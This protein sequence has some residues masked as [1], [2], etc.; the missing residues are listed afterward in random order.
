M[1]KSQT[2]YEYDRSER[3]YQAAVKR[4]NEIAR[5]TGTELDFSMLQLTDLPPQIGQLD[6]LK[7]LDLSNNQLA[8]LPADIGRLTNLED[9]DLK[10]N[11]L[12]SLPDEL[13][14]LDKLRYLDLSENP[15]PIPPEILADPHNPQAILTFYF[16]TRAAEAKGETRALMETKVAF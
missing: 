15:L 1:A 9:L 6:K 16:E 7:L 14:N 2:A 8:H 10:D 13:Y 11:Q 12:A 3:A 5:S 4:I